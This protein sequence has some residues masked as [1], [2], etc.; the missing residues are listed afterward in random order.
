[1]ADYM[2]HGQSSSF[3]QGDISVDANEM[4]RSIIRG[5]HNS[6]TSSSTWSWVISNQMNPPPPPIEHLL[7]PLHG[8]RPLSDPQSVRRTPVGNLSP[9]VENDEGGDDLPIDPSSLAMQDG[10]QPEVMSESGDN[11]LSPRSMGHA[12][13]KR[14]GRSV[15]GGFMSGQW[16]FPS[17]L[18][19][20]GQKSQRWLRQGTSSSPAIGMTTENTPPR[21]LSN[22]S[23]GPSN[24]QFA[25]YSHNSH[26]SSSASTQSWIISNQMNPPPLPVERTSSILLSPFHGPR[27][28]SDPLSVRR[29]VRNPSPEDS[30]DEGELSEGGD[31]NFSPIFMGNARSKLAGRSFIGGFISG[32]RRLPRIVGGQKSKKR[33][34]R[35]GTLRS[36]GTS[37]PATGMTTGITLPQYLSNPS[38]GPSNP[39]FAHRLSIAGA[40]PPDYSPN[41]FHIPPTPSPP[42]SVN[43]F[44]RHPEP[45]SPNS[46]TIIRVGPPLASEAIIEEQIS[47]FEGYAPSTPKTY[48]NDITPPAQTVHLPRVSYVYQP[49]IRTN[50]RIS[51]GPLP[52][53]TTGMSTAS[54]RMSP[55]RGISSVERPRD[56]LSSS[57]PTGPPQRNTSPLLPAVYPYPTPPYPHTAYPYGSHP[58]SMPVPVSH[59]A[60]L[61]ISP[62]VMGIFYFILFL[63]LFI[64]IFIFIFF[65]FVFV[66]FTFFIIR[67]R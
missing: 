63:F 18:R 10:Q 40:F 53:P 2:E 7:S 45:P 42:P 59:I 20:R 6:H 24:P 57:T 61:Q 28:L 49:S 27:P 55:P 8:P 15:I 22:P 60:P 56:F 21:Y 3:P 58:P 12:R 33:L 32:L 4:R 17:V 29:M 5:S 48:L 46:P 9:E 26:A 31:N 16:R 62:A 36:E 64:F 1:M 51:D 65:V 11:N 67:E 14:G 23:I 52:L 25:R 38:I 19:I 54:R 47:E 37:S 34:A 50:D 66:F 13:S 44:K 30:Y 41:S 35:Q 43:L 39:Q